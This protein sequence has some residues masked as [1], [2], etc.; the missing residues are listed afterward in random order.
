M[1]QKKL[2]KLE[3]LLKENSKAKK[4]AEQARREFEELLKE[5]GGDTGG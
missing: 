3:R 4:S 5:V 1:R 2:P